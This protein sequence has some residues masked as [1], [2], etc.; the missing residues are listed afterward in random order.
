MMDPQFEAKLAL[1]QQQEDEIAR[2]E[3]QLHD[4]TRMRQE[5]AHR[6]QLLADEAARRG[7][8]LDGSD[9]GDDGDD[10]D[11]SGIANAADLA[12]ANSARGGVLATV[13]DEEID[14]EEDDNDNEEDDEAA[15]SGEQRELLTMLEKMA[16]ELEL[17]EQRQQNLRNQHRSA[18]ASAASVA[19]HAAQEQIESP[20]IDDLMAR[21]IAASVGQK[22]APRWETSKVDAGG[23]D[24]PAAAVPAGGAADRAQ[25]GHDDQDGHD[26]GE[27]ADDDFGSNI[28]QASESRSMLSATTAMTAAT[29]AQK[30]VA[31]PPARQTLQTLQTEQIEARRE[32]E[33]D[34]QE[35]G[36]KIR[37]GM[38]QILEQLRELEQARR[39]AVLPEQRE[40]I[41]SMA[42]KL[43]Q[44]MAELQA[45]EQRLIYYQRMLAIAGAK[46][47]AS[48]EQAG[49]DE[50]DDEEEDGQMTP[51]ARL[52]PQLMAA[53]QAPA[54]KH[55]VCSTP[56]LQSHAQ[57]HSRTLATVSEQQG[58]GEEEQQ[59][60]SK[61]WVEPVDVHTLSEE[62]LD[63][64]EEQLSEDDD[65]DGDNGHGGG[66]VLRHTGTSAYGAVKGA[67]GIV[68]RKNRVTF[69]PDHASASSVAGSATLHDDNM[70]QLFAKHRDDIH[71]GAA[72]AI[73]SL[74]SS[75]FF[76]LSV[77]K[78]LPKLNSQYARERLLIALDEI[79][80]EAE[81]ADRAAERASAAAT[82]IL[83]PALTAAPVLTTA[84]ATSAFPTGHKADIISS[85]ISSS[86]SNVS[87]GD[88]LHDQGQ[89]LRQLILGSM[90]KHLVQVFES[91]G[92]T[93]FTAAQIDDVV[94]QV[95]S[96]IYAHLSFQRS[97]RD[98]KTARTDVGRDADD[99]DDA[100]ADG[101]DGADGASGSSAS[102][103]S[104]DVDV[105]AMRV[106]E[107]LRPAVAGV[108]QKY[109]GQ[110]VRASQT[111]MQAD[112]SQLL[113]TILDMPIPAASGSDGDDDRDGRD[114]VTVVRHQRPLRDDVDDV[115]DEDEEDE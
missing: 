51:Q 38:S 98:A 44:Q 19:A 21:L 91:S 69:A 86:N 62:F 71:R 95:N 54:P 105:R 42:E 113:G 81:A 24:G 90:D 3:Q 85:T 36:A 99:A 5:L 58:D 11:D 45:V 1:A 96:M 112:V 14:D 75:P 114:G 108:L 23:S 93:L 4:L 72:H 56:T 77:F 52:T 40:Q 83:P 111:R 13:A 2:L 33:F 109:V 41:D 80:E 12:H 49:Q 53:G 76:L 92:D 46:G 15:F 65:D 97:L 22:P 28:S 32:A 103:E 68:A 74:E 110:S 101:A 61:S 20:S 88:A 9:D 43:M 37:M 7:I 70:K 63:I 50:N 18:H 67:A 79:I 31:S 82:T 16:H 30:A 29:S 59:Q 107:R 104:S 64:L 94:L 27:G 73:A 89:T 115:E 66:K 57:L 48:G 47:Q 39:L 6:Q 102:S 34:I 106:V 78:R 55:V 60:D 10:R 25:H 87:T 100:D 17:V 35:S 84:H 8:E 26:D